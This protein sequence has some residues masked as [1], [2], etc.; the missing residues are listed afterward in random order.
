MNNQEFAIEMVN[1][2]D[3]NIASYLWVERNYNSELIN[4]IDEKLKL[5]EEEF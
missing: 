2:L 4:L 5:N 3:Y 1:M